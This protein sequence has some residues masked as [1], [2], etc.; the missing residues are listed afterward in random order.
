M[1]RSLRRVAAHA[2]PRRLYGDTVD[3]SI[4][5]PRVRRRLITDAVAETL[6]R[7]TFDPR[8]TLAATLT[9]LDV[10]GCTALTDRWLRDAVRTCVSLRRLRM[11][12]GGERP[13]DAAGFAALEEARAE[14]VVNSN[15]P[16]S[17]CGVLLVSVSWRGPRGGCT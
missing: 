1:K 9:V 5:P 11:I 13:M 4:L 14:A 17:C 15:A 6:V 2:P 3:L 12:S 10:S 8:F 16:S 7:R